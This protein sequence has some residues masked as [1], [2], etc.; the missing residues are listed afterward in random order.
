MSDK[1]DIEKFMRFLISLSNSYTVDKEGYV[2]DIVSGE[3]CTRS[4]GSEKLLMIM[5]NNLKDPDA[6]IINVVNETLRESATTRWFY[7]TI[8]TSLIQ[9]LVNIIFV[10]NGVV[11]DGDDADMTPHLTKIVSRYTGD[12]DTKTLS[13]FDSMI[14][15]IW[16]F[17]NIVYVKKNRTAHLRCALFEKDT[18]ITKG[19]RKKSTKVITKMMADL[20]GVKTEDE[21]LDKFTFKS[22]NISAPKLHAIL[23]VTMMIYEQAGEILSVV[24]SAH[25]MPD[26]TEFA[27]HI[28]NIDEY[29]KSVR[30]FTGSIETTEEEKPTPKAPG[31]MRVGN[32][33][34]PTRSSGQNASLIPTRAHRNQEKP[35]TRRLVIPSR[36]T[37][38]PTSRGNNSRGFRP[39]TRVPMRRF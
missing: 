1:V 22:N 2:V 38:I 20:L 28:R 15:D 5:K 37:M 29:Y 10:V 39:N 36:S 14:K 16:A 3:R 35:Q 31:M 6:E 26:L 32:V 27:Y 33:S 11:E 8:I 12:F 4:K 13:H 34:L 17:M 9:R 23:M 30:W 24:D 19:V 21:L 25:E 7:A 18:P